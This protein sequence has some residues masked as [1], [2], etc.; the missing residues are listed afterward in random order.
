MAQTGNQ[1]PSGDPGGY[2]EGERLDAIGDVNFPINLTCVVFVV[3][4]QVKG[5]RG[6]AIPEYITR[7]MYS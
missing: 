2:E 7:N 3:H 1:M 4:L 5:G 6:G